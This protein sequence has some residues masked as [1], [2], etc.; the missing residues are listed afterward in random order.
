MGNV[1]VDVIRLLSKDPAHLAGSD[2][3][4]DLLAQLR[5]ETPLTFDVISRSP[6]NRAKFDLAMMRELIDLP[7]LDV[8]V[9]GLASTDNS[10]AAELLRPFAAD[11][12][13]P[14]TDAH[15]HRLNLHFGLN[16][17]RVDADHGLTM[18]H[19]RQQHD[20]RTVTFIAD[21]AITAIGFTHA[22]GS[23]DGTPK[24]WCGENIY[25]V[26]WFSR[27]STGTIAENRKDAQRVAESIIED[28][29]SGRI[30]L[31]KNGFREIEQL[32]GDRL[33]T[34]SDWQRLEAFER[35]TARPNRCRQKVASIDQMITVARKSPR[36][37]AMP[38]RAG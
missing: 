3:N 4:D 38:M 2:I 5:V 26:G 24:T 20:G 36:T 17:E 12:S 33:I 29:R 25:R 15:C 28:V 23:A 30:P 9:T 37:A 8:H 10:P 35:D 13:T 31:A 19:V 7:N 27:G 1:S 6:A 34:F 16:P 21:T 14:R 11:A 18:L 32:L 22:N